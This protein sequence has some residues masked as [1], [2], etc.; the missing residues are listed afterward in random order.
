[1]AAGQGETAARE[2]EAIFD[3]ALANPGW[4]TLDRAG[5]EAHREYHEN[6]S[7][8]LDVALSHARAAIHAWPDQW[9]ITCSWSGIE[10]RLGNDDAALAAL[11]NADRLAD[12]RNSINRWPTY[13]GRHPA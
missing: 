13:E 7:G 3:T 10:G 11:E 5:I 4:N 9:V 8:N 1:M 6:V 2:L 12:N